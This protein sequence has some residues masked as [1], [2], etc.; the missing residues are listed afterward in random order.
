MIDAR[1]DHFFGSGCGECEVVD[2]TLTAVAL[3]HADR[4]DRFFNTDQM[5]YPPGQGKRQVTHAAI[6]FQDLLI[7][8]PGKNT[9]EDINQYL[10]LLQIDLSERSSAVVKSDLGRINVNLE[11]SVTTNRLQTLFRAKLNQQVGS[12]PGM[13]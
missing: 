2:G 1:F 4:Q 8:S 13:T 10:V 6:K 5:L 7:F 9:G 11:P 12:Q 3:G